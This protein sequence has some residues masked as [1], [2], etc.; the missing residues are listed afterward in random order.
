MRISSFFKEVIV[1]LK[2]TKWYTGKDLYHSTIS[3]IA[4][5]VI[6]SL[7]IFI[8]DIVL[9]KILLIVL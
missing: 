1:E 5:A 8:L 2:N 4:I 9:Q 3:V 6:I 7:I